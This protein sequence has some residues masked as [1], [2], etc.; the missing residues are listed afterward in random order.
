MTSLGTRIGQGVEAEVFATV[1]GYAL[2]LMRSPDHAARLGME[3]AALRA[4]AVAGV[5]TPRVYRQVVVD[6]RPGIEMQ[7]IQGVDLLTMIARRPWIVFHAGKLAGRTHAAIGAAPAPETLPAVRDVAGSVI[8][9]ML[10]VSPSPEIAWA[11]QVLAT[12]PD[13]DRL[14]HGDF[15]PGQMMVEGGEGVV[16][17]WATAKRGDP[18]FDH[19][20]TCVILRMG[21]PPPGTSAQPQALATVGRRLLTT[22]YMRSYRAAATFPIDAT[23][24]RSW[25][26]VCLALRLAAGLPGEARP[27]RASLTRAFVGRREKGL[28]V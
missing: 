17:D 3:V 7:R 23:R 24:L 26:V 8:D 16:L 20:L 6:G 15:H 19:A 9:R 10:Q 18:L 5:R 14:C 28:P 12:L 4:A 2:K 11:M 25:E 13:G 1:E 22:S 21:R 27:L